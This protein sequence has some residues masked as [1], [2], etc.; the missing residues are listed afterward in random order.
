MPYVNDRW[1]NSSELCQIIRGCGV[2]LMAAQPS[3]MVV[4]NMVRRVLKVVR[5][6][7]ERTSGTV[8]GSGATADAGEER[9]GGGGRVINFEIFRREL[10]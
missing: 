6:E 9:G 1:T 3:Q 7:E 2:R 4:G 10:Q 5:D 8:T